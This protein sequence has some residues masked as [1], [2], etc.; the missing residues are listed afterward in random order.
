MP[1]KGP[2]FYGELSLAQRKRLDQAI[3]RE[4][5]EKSKLSQTFLPDA[6]RSWRRE[7]YKPNEIDYDMCHIFR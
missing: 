6:Y 7:G 5:K 4:I 3:A 1:K 2:A